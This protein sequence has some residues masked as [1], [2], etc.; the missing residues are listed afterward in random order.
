[1]TIEREDAITPAMV[2]LSIAEGK[3]IMERLQ[4][5]MVAAQVQ[6]HGA[7][8]KSC[9]RCGKTFR[10]KGYY[11]STL[12]SVYGKVPMRVRR[13]KGCS[14]TGSQHRSYSTIFTNKNPITPELIP[15]H[16]ALAIE[17][18]PPQISTFPFISRKAPVLPD[19]SSPTQVNP[20]YGSARRRK[21]D[22]QF[23]SIA[24]LR[25]VR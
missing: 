11:Q 24:R 10:T 6:H 19:R 12:R 16:H 14:C 9:P 18:A 23:H 15:R 4:R 1:M 8:I 20:R 7:S 25:R 5:Q 3:T 13:F 22:A 17:H 2:G 21:P